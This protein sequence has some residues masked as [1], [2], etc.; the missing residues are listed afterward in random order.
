MADDSRVDVSINVSADGA[1]RG[2]Q[3]AS[4][5]LVQA[6]A[7]IENSLREL[8]AQSRS[9][10]A[11]MTAAFSGTAA[12]AQDMASRIG[13][14]VQQVT[15]ATGDSGSAIEST[16]R[17]I[18]AAHEGVAKA[19]EKAS[20]WTARSRSELIVL[21]HEMAMGNFK[22]L[23]GSLMVFAEQMDWMHKI[24]SPVGMTIG[25]IAG[26][27]AIASAVA[28]TAAE[29]MANYGDT[30]KKVSEETG[31]STAQVQ[32]WAFAAKATGASAN[33]AVRAFSQLGEVQNK[34]IHGN[35]DAAAAFAA[36][37]ISLTALR[38]ST[39][40]ELLS[41]IA[42][43][44]H[45]SADGAAKAAV[46]N[47]L[48]GASGASLIP[49]LDRGAAGLAQLGEEAR[50][51]GAII[52]DDTIK[53]MAALKEETELA[54]AKMD[55][56]SMSAKTV[57]LP[58]IINLTSAL[59]DNAALKPI[60]VEFYK[61]VADVVKGAASVF[62]TLVVGAQQA[63]IAI[64]TVATIVNRAGAGDISGV[65]NAAKAGF[66]AIKTEGEHYT[67]FMQKVWSDAAPSTTH[68]DTTGN[69]HIDFS[70]GKGHQGGAVT[71]GQEN[72]AA[73]AQTNADL[74][75]LREKLK[76][77]QQELDRSYKMQQVSL[78][79]YY[80]QRL[81]ITL[82]GMDAEID[83]VK[84]QLAT[85]QGLEAKAKTPAERI[86]MKTKEIELTGKLAVM[87]QQRAYAVTQ[88]NQ[89]ELAAAQAQERALT[90]I[91]SRRTI[92]AVQE[93]GKRAL[94]IAEAERRAGLITA[95]QLFEMQQQFQDQET[96]A[97]ILALQHRLDTEKD[98]TVQARQQI[99]DQ[100]AAMRDQ[101][102]TRELQQAIQFNQQQQAVAEQAATGIEDGFS[103]AFGNFVDGTQTARQAFTQFVNQIDQQLTQ[104]VA[105]KFF[106]QL[107]EMPFSGEKGGMSFDSLLRSGTS[108]LL[109]DDG[110]GTAATAAHTTAVTADTTSMTALTAAATAATTALSALAASA[111]GSTAGNLSGLGGAGGGLG[112]LFGEGTGG[113]NAWGFTMP[114]GSAGDI[115]PAGL[116]GNAWGFTMPS[117]D[118]GTPYVPND[119]IAQI[120]EGERIVPAH[121]NSPFNPGN[122]SVSN[123]F[124]LP[125]G[126]DLRTQSQIASMA[127]GAIQRAMQRNG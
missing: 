40:T 54:H 92:Q 44:F 9:S 64:S 30:V 85:T 32:E 27:L 10:T 49:L 113:S 91:E 79:D 67:K 104:M 11:A 36:L 69:R 57:L 41:K 98:L 48:F 126:I 45:G 122:V 58:T 21:F 7:N 74:A 24:M 108:K 16:S 127:G 76:E 19:G 39:P 75:M 105:K 26:S 97:D 33:E 52:G 100:I 116:G 12:G 87:E 34:A 94:M 66:N 8:V 83:A 114:D 110:A 112:G 68:K 31:A 2:S 23:G 35:H 124:V 99:E 37:G 125:N 101:A 61:D 18:V 86:S 29:A 103:R 78:R 96:Q 84:N 102:N 63:G 56:M 120:H 90:D 81:Q 15:R 43:A 59:S 109:G 115:M 6:I 20:K 88:S 118:V 17:R 25:A 13:T 107:E 70:K 119:M 3:E 42:D 73:Q 117:F 121:L 80:A 51:A 123:Q 82:Q 1:E 4:Q 50:N 47:E 106:Q 89:E 72:S 55:A 111:Y 71:L 65:V 14:S 46:A 38:T 5:A 62:A 77:E 60:L 93:A 28:Y 53:Q 22:R 95:Q